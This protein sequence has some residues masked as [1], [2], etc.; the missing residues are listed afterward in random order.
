LL[1]NIE[2]FADIAVNIKRDFTDL[3][4]AVQNICFPLNE[5]RIRLIMI[6]EIG[7]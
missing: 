4:K 1:I 5:E 3:L 2:L 7:I 6:F